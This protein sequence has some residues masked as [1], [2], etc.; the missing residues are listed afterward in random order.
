MRYTIGVSNGTIHSPENF[1]WIHANNLTFRAG[2]PELAKAK[3]TFVIL[4]DPY[5]RIAS[6]FI[7]KFIDQNDVAWNFYARTGRKKNPHELS[8]RNFID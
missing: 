2:L 5:T 8:F 3:Y 7:D 1:D 6:C 4:R